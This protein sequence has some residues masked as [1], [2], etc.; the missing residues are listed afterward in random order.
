MPAKEHQLEFK[1]D[2]LFSQHVF[3]EI[4]IYDKHRDEVQSLVT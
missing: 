2:L 4:H 1:L 3:F